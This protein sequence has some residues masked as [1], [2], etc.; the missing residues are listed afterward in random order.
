MALLLDELLQVKRI[1]ENEAIKVMKEKELQLDQCRKILE[2]KIMKHEKYT[3]WRKAEERRL[4]EE[5]LHKT[6]RAYNLNTMRDQITSFKEKHQQLQEEIEKAEAA[7]TEAAEHLAAAR[8][9]RMNAYKTVQKYKEYKDIIQTIE[10]KE[11]EKR[12]ELEAEEFNL[13]LVH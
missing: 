6:V 1:R 5:I 4:Y 8:L 7:V 9:A 10:D 2:D 13:R 12:T 3:V 11:A